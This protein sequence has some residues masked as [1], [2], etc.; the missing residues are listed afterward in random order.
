V[1]HSIGGGHHVLPTPTRTIPA[2][3]TSPEGAHS[4]AGARDRGGSS[5]T[6][7]GYGMTLA[8]LEVRYPSVSLDHVDAE[9]FDR[10]T[11]VVRI[12]SPTLSP[13]PLWSSG[14]TRD[15]ILER[16]GSSCRAETMA[17]RRHASWR[18]HSWRLPRPACVGG[19][20]ASIVR[21]RAVGREDAPRPAGKAL[22]LSK[23]TKT[24]VSALR[25]KPVQ[26]GSGGSLAQGVESTS[27]RYKRGS[28]P[29]SSRTTRTSI[30]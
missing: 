7:L 20:G 15:A 1:V 9:S 4:A 5:A 16:F 11:P 30:S 6:A 3:I 25:S 26:R 19:P 12:L 8:K 2:R 18:Q 13:S 14:P 24:T 10:R 27:T 17:H 22:D 23:I 21:C 29:R 28:S